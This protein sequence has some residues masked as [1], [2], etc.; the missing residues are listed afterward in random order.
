MTSSSV[1]PFEFPA[2]VGGELRAHACVHCGTLT[3]APED[4]GG[5]V[6]C[7][8]GCRAVYT[9]IHEAGLG[10]YYA[11]REK[12]APRAREPAS[13]VG[14]L[15]RFRELESPELIRERHADGHVSAELTVEGIHCG[16]CV[17]LLESLPRVASG[18]SESR[19]DLGRSRLKVCW[20]PQVTSLGRIAERLAGFGYTLH[21]SRDG[22]ER[23]GADRALLLRLG[24]AGA[25]AG[26]VMLLALGLYSGAGESSEG[27][28][29]TLFRWLSL[30]LSLPAV[31]Y[32]AVPFYRGAWAS[33]HTRRPS[34]DLPIALGVS[35][36]FVSGAINT[37]RG[38]GEIYF[39]TI[40]VLIFLLLV[41]RWLNAREQRRAATAADFA[42]ALAPNTAR[43]LEGDER[44]EVLARSVPIGSLVEVLPGERI[45]VD[46]RIE[47]GESAIDVRL[48][49]GESAPQEGKPGDRVYAGTENLSASLC[50]A[51]EQSGE[52]TRVGQILSAMLD[53]Q[54]ERAPIVRAAD[55]LAGYFVLA[56]LLCAG[57]TFAL[58]FPVSPERAVDHAIALLV[59]TCPCA[60]GMATPLAVSIALTRAAR[61]GIL[62]KSG[63]VL[64]A[65]ARPA[66]LLFDKSGTLTTGRPELA[67][68]H[69]SEALGRRVAAA[70]RG[71]D[72]PLARAFLR[73]FSSDGGGPSVE[74][75]EPSELALPKVTAAHVE[76]FTGGGIRAN[77]E[78]HDLWVG[79]PALFES[80]GLTI[81]RELTELVNVHAARGLTPVL[82]AEDGHA[83]GFAAFGD[84]LRPDARAS[85]QRL[86]ELGYPIH[87]LSGDHPLVVARIAEELPVLSAAGG[88]SPERKLAEVQ[89]RLS[90]GVGVIMVGDGMN[91]AAA[92]SLATV[93]FAVHGG[94]EASLLAA[95][96]FS[97]T[98]GVAP[99][100]EAI[101]GARQTLFAI[102]RGLAFSLAYNVLGVALAMTGVLSPLWAAVLMP[103]SSLTVLTSALAS[104]AFREA[105]PTRAEASLPARPRAPE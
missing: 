65:L 95:R 48:L 1:E 61:R 72:H 74:G 10:A 75:R 13:G 31:G 92:M 49:T 36:G 29:G 60:L 21:A 23:A 15:R 56:V 99:V 8:S 62:L 66:E 7:C 83:A 30:L 47:R 14:T 84:V 94:A 4:A 81:P 93:G 89:A 73:A 76:Q 91:D 34:M 69:G 70:E 41:G 67:V 19:L 46:G 85:L 43:V 100:L 16:A 96:G 6:F 103:L 22:V 101:L 57:L 90:R 17:W 45:P 82:V 71:S 55:R 102:Y 54:R 12:A 53:A 33:L 35:A 20:D 26:N 3:V 98:P 42:Q 64:E 11:E 68:W 63:E 87:V 51:T 5:N 28:Y 86:S 32:C 18:V 2:A 59:V 105:R 58:W 37:L 104:R 44:R 78:G 80:A 97:T 27:A 40:T 9:A 52:Q 38:Q 88:V 77:V 50:I 39:D 24:V 25:I 79:S